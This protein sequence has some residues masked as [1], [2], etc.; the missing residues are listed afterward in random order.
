M[1][2]DKPLNEQFID[3]DP[4]QEAYHESIVENPE[5]IIQEKRGDVAL[6]C[7]DMQ[8]LDAAQGYGIFADVMN[9]GVPIEAQEYYFSTLKEVV[10]PNVRK[11]QDTFRERNLE[12]IHVRIQ[13]LTNDGRDRS[14]NHRNLHIHAAPGSKEA[15][16][17]PEIAPQEDEII[18]N[19]TA[20]GVFNS[21]NVHYVL[22]NM[23]IKSLFITGVYT[24]ECVETTVRDASDR[25]YNVTVIED[26][27][28]TVTKQLHEFSL[29]TVKDRYARVITT[30]EVIEEICELIHN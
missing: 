8:Y 3:V 6:M 9:S 27:C 21:T 28:T 24:N 18:I 1:K 5:R 16:F 26:G 19:K 30:E 22:S 13:S 11:L 20:S 2:I 12:I 17:L 4:L 7:I 23:G 29:A 25:G 10:L 14:G 15:E